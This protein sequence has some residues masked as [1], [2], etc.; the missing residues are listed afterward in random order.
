MITILAGDSHILIKQDNFY[1]LHFDMPCF[2]FL[3]YFIILRP[4]CNAFAD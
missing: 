4:E 1:A 2:F 3:G